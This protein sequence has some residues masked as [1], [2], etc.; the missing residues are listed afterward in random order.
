MKMDKLWRFEKNKGHKQIEVA[1]YFTLQATSSLPWNNN[2]LFRN[3]KIPRIHTVY[4]SRVIK[5]C[6]TRAYLTGAQTRLAFLNQK[7]K[8]KEKR[9]VLVRRLFHALTRENWLARNWKRV[10]EL[11][12]RRRIQP[13]NINLPLEWLSYNLTSWKWHQL[14]RLGK[15]IFTQERIRKFLSFENIYSLKWRI[16]SRYAEA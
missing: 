14:R 10:V 1:R 6:Q 12:R 9:K 16:K 2:P 4:W 15:F 3:D 11:E 7:R 8:K 5:T 13:W